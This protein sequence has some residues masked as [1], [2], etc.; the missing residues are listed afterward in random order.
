VH[1]TNREVECLGC[2]ERT[3]PQPAVDRFL[4]ERRC[5]ACA[6]CGGLLK[7][8]TISF[9]QALDPRVLR[10]AETAAG[11]CDLVLALGSTLTVYPAAAIPMTAARAGV[12]YAIVNR[13][14]TD[15]DSLA[16]LRIEGDVVEVLPAAV[17][18]LAPA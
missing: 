8:A 18:G 13:G 11:D 14:E 5:P 6:D 10:D 12:P 1:G 3:P 16:T 15:H 7:F 17:E 2:G 9:G 4:A